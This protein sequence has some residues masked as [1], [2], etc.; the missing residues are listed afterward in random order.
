MDVTKR[1]L[2]A[3]APAA[4]LAGAGFAG[5]A[6]AQESASA[7][8][9][10]PRRKATTRLLF[11]SPSGFPNALASSPE[12]LW[13]A[14]QKPR[15]L[16]KRRYGLTYPEDST[17]LI[18][19]VDDTGKVL[20]TLV[21]PGRNTSGLALGNGSIWSC[22]LAPAEM[23]GVY[24]LDMNGR[25]ISHRQ[26]PLGPPEDGG[27]AHGAF[28][29]DG[30]LWIFA[31]RFNGVMRL[32]TASWTP[33]YLIPFPEAVAPRYHGVAW[34]NGAIWAV[35]GNDSPGYKTGK[36][37]LAK[38]DAASGRLLEIVEFV[39]GSAD[40]HGLV[41]HK[42]KLLSCD[43]GIHPGWPVGDSPTWGNIFEINFV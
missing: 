32:D 20:R 43:A 26:I 18:W 10:V 34:D 15:G 2:V 4:L 16:T 38:F 6:R 37:G 28:W 13:V 5:R 3:A 1:Q 41:L 7:I 9:K 36:F 14:E 8:A 39:D 22:A 42:G 27:G 23:D 19:L 30:K 11:K 40:P 24:Q 12:G 31:N 33:E 25:L 17:E 29:H 35:T 21:T